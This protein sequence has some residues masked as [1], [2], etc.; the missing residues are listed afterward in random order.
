MKTYQKEF[1]VFSLRNSV[2]CFGEYTLKSGRIS[3]YFFNAGLF[4]DASAITKLGEFYADIIED[5][6][7][8]QYDLLF[9]PAY[10]GIPLATATAINL[11]IKYNCNPDV[12]FNRKEEKSHGEGKLIIGSSLKDKRVI[13]IDDVI[14]AGITIT[15][16][17]QLIHN[18]GGS[19]LAVVIMLDR[20]ERGAL[21][22]LS[23]IQD[24]VEKNKIKIISI[25]TLNDLIEYLK[26]I[27]ENSAMNRHLKNI[28]LY[29][30]QYGLLV[31]R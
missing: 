4:N 18:E 19:C 7:S 31:S 8:G 29:Q 13:I 20:L 11:K 30:S 27:D 21:T 2:L 12:S 5:N 28:L 26:D 3:P 6:F 17:I 10:K 1:I 14:T 22:T 9:G 23:A 25:I 16:S 15:E 24:I